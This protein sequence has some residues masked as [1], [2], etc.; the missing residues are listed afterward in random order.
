MAREGR[1][2]WHVVSAFLVPPFKRKKFVGQSPSNVF[3]CMKPGREMPMPWALLPQVDF[4]QQ[5]D[6]SEESSE[7]TSEGCGRHWF[8]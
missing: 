3:L 6:Q 1:V 7:N 2:S 4:D 5:G 8:A